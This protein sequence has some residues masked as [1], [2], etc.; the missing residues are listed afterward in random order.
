MLWV[1]GFLQHHAKG[2][3]LVNDTPMDLSDYPVVDYMTWH[4]FYPDAVEELPPDQVTHRSVTG[5]LL[6]MN[7][8][9]IRWV[10]KRQKT[11]ET[12]TYSSETVAARISVELIE[13]YRYALRMLGVPIEGPAKMLGDNKSVIMSTTILSLALKKKHNAVAYHCVREAIAAGIITFTHVES[14]RN[15]ADI[16][17]KALGNEQFM[18]LVVPLMFRMPRF[19]CLDA[20]LPVSPKADE[21]GNNGQ[22]E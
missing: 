2:R 12:S 18:T 13:E 6:F 14:K 11:F 5:I 3:I 20:A 21:I 1:Y 10:S 8:M 22:S 16:L 19:D 17:T 9:P 4:Q 7:G 15:Y